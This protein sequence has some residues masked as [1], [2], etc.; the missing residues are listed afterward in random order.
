MREAQLHHV[1][2]IE[3]EGLQKVLERGVKEREPGRAVLVVDGHEHGVERGDDQLQA[4]LLA[5]ADLTAPERA[6]AR[7]PQVG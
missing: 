3:P 7:L 4:A 1:R 2:V 5:D 6:N